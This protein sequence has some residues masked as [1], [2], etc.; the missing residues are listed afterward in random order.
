MAL[1][2][3]PG[4]HRVALNYLLSNVQPAANVIHVRETG[5]VMTPAAVASSVATAWTQVVSNVNFSNQVKFTSVRV[6][7]L[8]GSTAPVELATETV[9]TNT[10]NMMPHQCAIVVTL[11]TAFI[12]RTKRGRM[13]L[14]AGT[15]A[16]S[17]NTDASK[18]S[19]QF[20]DTVAGL[21]EVFNNDINSDTLQQVVASYTTATAAAVTTWVGR[22]SIYT[23]RRRV[24]R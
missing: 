19:Q 12:G 20:A 2:V 8:D 5:D 18:V 10:A 15:E 7:P 3:I 14:P 4:V 11:R 22:T 23:Q 24:G 17:E 16:T 13:Y 21:V 6:T 9:G 1:P